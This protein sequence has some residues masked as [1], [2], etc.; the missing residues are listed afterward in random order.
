MKKEVT[1]RC[2]IIVM[3][4]KLIATVDNR[5]FREVERFTGERD[6]QRPSQ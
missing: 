6:R 5:K 2:M 1:G 4:G 3:L